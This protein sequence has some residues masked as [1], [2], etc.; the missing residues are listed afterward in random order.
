MGIFCNSLAY[1]TDTFDSGGTFA[2]S[3]FGAH[4]VSLDYVVLEE[5]G[6]RL[7]SSPTKR[8]LTRLLQEEGTTFM[9]VRRKQNILDLI[10]L[11]LSLTRRRLILLSQFG[12]DMASTLTSWK[13]YRGP[14]EHRRPRDDYGIAWYL[15]Y[16]SPASFLCRVLRSSVHRRQI[17]SDTARADRMLSGC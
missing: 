15:R 12:G 11:A 6:D 3:N 16:V 13:H 7:R 17:S 14:P 10:R 1:L 4:D 8:S 5:V 9:R 2:F